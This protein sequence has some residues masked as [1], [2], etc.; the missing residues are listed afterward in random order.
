MTTQLDPVT[1]FRPTYAIPNI[2]GTFIGLGRNRIINGEMI[3]DQANGG[4]LVSVTSVNSSVDQMIGQVNGAGIFSLQRQTATP[5][6]GFN[7]YLRASC[8]TADVSIAASDLYRIFM[9]LEGNNVR[10]FLWGTASTKA[11][12]M[13]FWVRSSLTGTYTGSVRNPA[14]NSSYSFEYTVDAVNTWERKIITLPGDTTGVMNTDSTTGVEISWSFALGVT[15][16]GTANVWSTPTGFGTANQVNWMSSN[17]A[18]TW[19]ITGVQLEIGPSATAFE[20]RPFPIEI[21]LCQRYYEK[22]YDLDT[23]PGTVTSIGRYTLMDLAAS[24][25]STPGRELAWKVIKR[26]A[27]SVFQ[28]YHPNTGAAGQVTITNF[29]GVGGSATFSP[30]TG[31]MGSAQWSVTGATGLTAGQSYRIDCHWTVDARL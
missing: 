14:A 25:T 24:T 26:A 27:P 17:S 9:R 11:I 18:R 16:Q 10:D 2:G 23:P 7:F 28:M 8:T 13:S 22:S 30:A 4:N 5:P 20:Y 3:I 19:D 29:V 1:D 31:G 12:T 21:Q 15:S 6:A